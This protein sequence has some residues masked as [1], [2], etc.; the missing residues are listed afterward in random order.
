MARSFSREQ[1]A[2]FGEALMPEFTRRRAAGEDIES[3]TLGAICELRERDP[4]TYRRLTE[5]RPCKD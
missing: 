1:A 2:A 4:A 3:A 5:K